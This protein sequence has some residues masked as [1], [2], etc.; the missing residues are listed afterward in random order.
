MELECAWSLDRLEVGPLNWTLPF[1]PRRCSLAEM[2]AL[3]SGQLINCTVGDSGFFGKK[4]DKWG[5]PKILT[6]NHPQDG[7]G[8]FWLPRPIWEPFSH[9][10][11]GQHHNILT[12]S[13]E[14][15]MEHP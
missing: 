6:S 5:C 13:P 3:G 14:K 15:P 2:F 11:K 7:R 12:K 4:R 9:P 10:K 8:N 1:W